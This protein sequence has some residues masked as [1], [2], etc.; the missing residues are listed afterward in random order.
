MKISKNSMETIQ[1]QIWLFKFASNTVWSTDPC[2]IEVDQFCISSLLVLGSKK[3][4][5]FNF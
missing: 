3:L 1:R 5:N 2:K 4:D